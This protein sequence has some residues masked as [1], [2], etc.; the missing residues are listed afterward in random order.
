MA[1]PANSLKQAD[2]TA[3]YIVVGGGSAGAIVASRLSERPDVKVLLIEAGG[4]ARSPIIRMPAGVVRLIGNPK[5]D[6]SYE[7]VPAP[8]INDRHF[9]WSAGKLLGG[10]SSINGTVF[11]RGTRRDYDRW[12]ELGATGWGYEG[13]LP[14]F[15]RSEAWTGA[16]A[17]TRGS[18][19]PLSVSPMQPGYHPLVDKFVQASREHGLE[20][21]EDYNADVKEGVFYTQASQRKGVRCNTE[22]AYLRGARSRSNLQ[23]LTNATVGKILFAGK[24]AVGVE[25]VRNGKTERATAVREVVVST[26]AMGSP[27]LLMRSGIGAA[28]YLSGRGIPVVMDLPGVGQNLQEHPGVGQSKLINVPSFNS[29]T[30][31]LDVIRY[32]LRYMWN[33]TGPMASPAV[34]AMA[35]LRSQPDLD[36]PDAQIHFFPLSYEV[37]PNTTSFNTVGMSTD[38]MLTLHVSLCHP[39]S[40]GHVELDDAG[41]PRVH[42]QMLG[43]QRD[44]DSMV[45]S[46]KYINRMFETPT[47][48]QIVIGDRGPNPVP[49]SDEAWAEYARAKAAPGYHPVGTCR[50]GSDELAVVDPLLRVRGVHGLRVVD[51][52]VMPTL[53]SVNTNASAIMVGEKGAQII[54]DDAR[55]ARA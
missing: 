9:G 29:Q 39:F 38:P 55:Q 34:P 20:F 54:A 44:M 21:L 42:H 36:E 16:P 46:L 48:K 47:M 43:D 49:T 45:S 11:I 40:R 28:G 12:E 53:P 52:S 19:G 32:M 6:W 25:F 22:V 5:F 27:G 3:D 2:F 15:M 30:G 7:E 17:Q 31:K 51:A 35:L 50:I 8:S 33:R 24:T 26:G 41:R 37:D 13:V 23:I 10:S 4:E 1:Q 14:Y 18:H